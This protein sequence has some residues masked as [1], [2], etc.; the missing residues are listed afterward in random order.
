MSSI[1]NPVPSKDL[2]PVTFKYKLLTRPR[3]IRLLYRTSKNSPDAVAEEPAYTLEH[4]NLDDDPPY[5]ATSYVWGSDELTDKITVNSL[6]ACVTNSPYHAVKVVFSHSR[7]VCP[8]FPSKRMSLWVDGLCINQS[9]DEEKNA[10]VSL[11]SEIYRKAM[12]VTLYAAK[13]GV[14]SDGALNW[15]GSAVSGWTLISTMTLQSGH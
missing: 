11:M 5:I 10:Q 1:S 13:E 2:K 4:V 7:D 9:D 8:Y 15:R 12:M 14:V 3:Q 6:E